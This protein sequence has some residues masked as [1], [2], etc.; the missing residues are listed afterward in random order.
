MA[1][2]DY[3]KDEKSLYLPKA[4]PG[5]ADVPEMPFLM[6]DGTGDPRG[7]AYQQAVSLLYGLSY[8]I[9]MKGRDWPGYMG[10]AVYPLE[11]LWWLE[12]GPFSFTDR[13][14]WLWTSMIRQ[15]AFVTPQ[16]LQWAVELTRKKK[17]GLNYAAVRLEHFTEGLCVQMMHLGPYA[18]EPATV[19][20]MRGF[21]EK[22]GL[23]DM[24]GTERKHHEIY[25][26]DPNKAAPEKMKTVLRHPVERI[27]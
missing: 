16:V 8:T 6:V 11:G 15:P 2:L 23:R 4:A 19:E 13:E 25:L 20:A 1:K 24:T 27:G 17:P 5:V 21:M 18:E 10:Y 14:G 9:K 7:E 26:S 12:N 3:K 22:E